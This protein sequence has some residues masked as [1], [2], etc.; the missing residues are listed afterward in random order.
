MDDTLD[1]ALTVPQRIKRGQMARKNKSK[2][3]RARKLAARRLANNEKLQKRS[4][5]AARQLLRKRVAG[6]QGANYANLS[7]SQK[8]AVDKMLDKKGAAIGKLAKRLMPRVKKAEYQRLQSYLKGTKLKH[9]T[10]KPVNEAEEPTNPI[11]K[12]FGDK[13]KDIIILGRF[14]DKT[15]K[16]LKKK[17]EKCGIEEGVLGQVYQRGLDSWDESSKLSPEQFAFSRVNSFIN[18][19]RNYFE[20][21]SDLVEVKNFKVDVVYTT[22]TGEHATKRNTVKANSQAEAEKI[23]KGEVK[24]GKPRT[25]V[26]HVLTHRESIEEDYD[27]TK[28]KKNQYVYLNK[29]TKENSPTGG[30][31]VKVTDTHTIINPGIGG[32]HYRV[33]HSDITTKRENSW[34]SKNYRKNNPVNE[35]SEAGYKLVDRGSHDKNPDK[36]VLRTLRHQE[37]KKKIVDEETVDEEVKSAEKSPVIVPAHYDQYGNSIPAKTVMRKKGR[38]ILKTGN[39]HDGKDK[40]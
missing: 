2:L 6:K 11:D 20:E 31:I 29:K 21:D 7:A 33:P 30:K 14:D 39:V 19:G 36:K 32:R 15:Q 34:I 13:F 24:D 37:L 9:M 26:N 27:H 35:A 23:A 38:S 16:A 12:K 40:D 10:A 18:E 5:K 17:S 28:A 1:E 4:R 22:R 25:K 3:K 8:M